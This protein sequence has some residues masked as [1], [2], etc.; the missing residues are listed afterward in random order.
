[1]IPKALSAITEE[2][3]QALITNGIAEGRSIDYKRDLPGNSDGEKKEL[4]ADVSSFA[5]TGG[6]DLVFGMEEAGGLPTQITGT[7]AAD[8]DLEVRRLDSIIAAG[9]SP[10]I[11]HTIKAVTTVAGP[12]VLIIRVERSWA[13]PHRV[14]F[15]N[16]DKFWGRNSAG[17]YSLDVNELRA[18]FTLSNTANEKIRAFRT[19]RIISLTNGDTPV[20]F[21]GSPKVIIHFIPLEAFA[22]GP[23]YDVR[24]IYDNPQLIAPMGTTVSSHRLNLEG[25]VAFGSR[26]PCD[27]YTQLFRN[28]VLEVVQGRILAVQHE[29]R[30]V[31]PSVAFEE[32]I[33]RYLPQ[34]FRLLETIGAGLPV[35]VAM[36]LT[37]TK[38]VWMG[39]DTFHR[40]E[41]GYPIDAERVILPETIVESFTTPAPEILK[42]M[43]D[44]LWNACGFPGSENF[45]ADGNWVGRRW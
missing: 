26:Q 10:R 13:G 30:L 43:F 17:K 8:L 24:P 5:N 35:V 29:G 31:I 21:M 27:T 18:A 37:H 11:R 20:P 36:T 9:L 2:D 33:V 40:G 25:V 45:D 4:L 41:A 42:P 1:V 28:G 38:G 23:T 22:G 15:Q 7:G 34:C 12:S 19:D 3:L 32:Y 6:G 44:L 14:I 39:V 16:H